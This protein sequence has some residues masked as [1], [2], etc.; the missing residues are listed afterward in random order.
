M[1]FLC[2]CYYNLAQFAA[3]SRDEMGAFAASCKPHDEALRRTGRL[4]AVGSLA[5]PE[6]SKTLRVEKGET[7]AKLSDGPYAPTPDPVG[8]FFIIEAADADEAAR[9]AALHP[10]AH[11]GR[12]MRGA[13]EI[14]PCEGFELA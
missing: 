12:F 13:I 4:F 7:A 2:L 11:A 10:G 14:W 3:M 1:K 5:L 8:A 9:I 6:A